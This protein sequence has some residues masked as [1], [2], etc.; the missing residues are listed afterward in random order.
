MAELTVADIVKPKREK[1][2][3]RIEEH[4][5]YTFEL[6]TKRETA[7]PIDKETSLPLGTGFQP[8]FSIPNEGN[9]WNENNSRFEKWRY[10]E[11]QDSCF[12]S[13]QPDLENY[14]KKDI[15][16]LLASPENDLEFRD[17]RMLVRGD[18]SGKLRIQALQLSDYF[19]DNKKPSK[20]VPS[21]F[22]FKLNNP[23]AVV[24]EQLDMFDLEQKTMAQALKL[25]VNEMLA[26]SMLLGINIEDQ[27]PEG[28]NR[29]KHAFLS[30]ARYDVRNPKSLDTFLEIINNP[31]TKINYIFSQGIAKGLISANVHPGKLSWVKLQTPILDLQGKVRTVD[32]LTTRVLNK[33]KIVVNLMAEVENQL[34]SLD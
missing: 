6:C 7:R 25:K 8:S 15:D 11:G 29:I 16:T 20:Q 28:L 19:I 21:H 14:E 9:A 31:T 34:N 4:K 12:V 18:H 27:T 22:K 32:E 17:G 5:I 26:V 10:I 30:K 23:D 24:E 3:P 1:G 33:E 13:E 2:S